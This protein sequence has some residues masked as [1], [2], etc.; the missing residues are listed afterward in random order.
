MIGLFFGCF[1]HIQICSF[2]LAQ[3]LDVQKAE[4]HPLVHV[5]LVLLLSSFVA[6]NPR[7][8]TYP[9]TLLPGGGGNLT[10]LWYGVVPFFRVP[11]S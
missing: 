7:D 11:F 6:S 8:R 3:T 10:C 4:E 2:N 9:F 5:V 1:V